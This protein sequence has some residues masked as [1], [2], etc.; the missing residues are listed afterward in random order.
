M[1]EISKESIL[2][3]IGSG[4]DHHIALPT[5][6]ASGGILIAWRHSIGPAGAHRIDSHLYSSVLT[7]MEHG[8]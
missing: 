7:A 5:V 4:F 1:S 3:T 8:D 6:G 2:S